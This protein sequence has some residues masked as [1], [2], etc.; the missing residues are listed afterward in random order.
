MLNIIKKNQTEILDLNKSINEIK[1]KIESFNS[2]LDQAEE[3]I[4]EFKVGPFEIIQYTKEEENK[5]IK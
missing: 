2:R 3:T 1:N 4:S 5:R